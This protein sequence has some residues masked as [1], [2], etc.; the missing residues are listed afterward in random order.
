[1]TEADS[2]LQIELDSGKRV[3][4]KAANVLLRFEQPEPAELIAR[5]SRIAARDRPRPRLGVRARSRVRL[6]RPRPR[7]LRR[8]RGDDEAGRRPAPPVRGAAL[9]PPARQG[10]FKKAPEE[11]VK[12]A[13]LGIERKKQV[14][15]QIDAWAAEL[16]AGELPAAGPRAA[17]QASSSSRTRTRPNTRPWSRPRG[18]ASSAPLDL[19]TAGRR[20]RFALPVPLAPL[21]VR[22][23][24]EGH[25]LPGARGAGDPAKRCRSRRRRPSR[26]TTRRPPRSTTR[27][28]CR[29]SAPAGR[30]SA[31]TSPRP[32][33]PSCPT[34]RST[35]SRASRLS[36]VYM[37]G[38]KLTMLPDEVVAGL[39]ARSRARMPGRLALRD[40]RRSHA[41]D[42]R[43]ETR[44]E[45]VPIAANLRHDQLDAVITEA[46]LAGEAPADYPFAAEL[47]SRSASP[48]T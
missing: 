36:T 25:R 46:T 38:H 33:S 27:S 37:P 2:S 14:A 28:R 22:E 9:L 30:A 8:E 18:G 48:G 23:L 39:H 13:L 35:R 42:D 11:I 26:S 6:R 40:A 12:A 45:R 21:P 34:R 31:S 32:A 3:K 19:L 5:A 4:V 47:A 1:M 10:H 29:A 20:D 44:L 24:P 15:A 17:L 16:V 7:L 41:R 43:H